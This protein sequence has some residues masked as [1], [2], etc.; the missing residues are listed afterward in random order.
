MTPVAT[1]SSLTPATIRQAVNELSRVDP[2][3]AAIAQRHGPPPLWSKRPGFATLALMILEQQVSL[4]AARTIYK[5]L[6]RQ[7]GGRVTAPR[8]AACSIED[9]RAAGITGGKSSYI[10]GLAQAV[11]TGDIDLAA[12]AH[13]DD[14]EVRCQL[15]ALRGIGPWTAD[16]YLLMVLRRPDVWPVGDL[17]LAISMERVK[18]M[19]QRPD[20]DQQQRTSR[21]WRP[22]RS[23]AARL[24]WQDYLV[25]QRGRS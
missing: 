2:D 4:K 5:R 13:L 15:T 16:V 12:L 3:L 19:R 7:V 24:L 23:V 21:S 14:D 1:V 11:M 17:A 22:W 9:L 18:R 25:I 8:I 10:I 20:A 6:Q